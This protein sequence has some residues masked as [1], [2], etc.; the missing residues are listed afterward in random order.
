MKP[1]NVFFL[2]LSLFSATGCITSNNN[3]NQIKIEDILGSWTLTDESLEQ[4][5]SETPA[6]LFITGFHLNADSTATVSFGKS[7]EKAGYWIW[8]AEKKTGNNTFGVSI[9]SDVLIKADGIPYSSLRLSN[10]QGK[11]FLRSNDFVYKKKE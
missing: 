4:L 2:I 11:I 6:T 1:N 9:E 10:E 3:T 8:K 7:S 5:S